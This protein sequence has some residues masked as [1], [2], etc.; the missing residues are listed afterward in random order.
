MCY[1]D[2]LPANQTV[3]FLFKGKGTKKTNKSQTDRWGWRGEIQGLSYT[4]PTNYMQP[5][6]AM[7]KVQHKIRELLKTSQVVPLGFNM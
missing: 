4:W 3:L 5:R 1:I 7:S 6:T 2:L